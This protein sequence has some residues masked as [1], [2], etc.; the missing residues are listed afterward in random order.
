MAS[1]LSDIAAGREMLRRMT[2]D[3]VAVRQV[4]GRGGVV[5]EV[6]SFF[7]MLAGVVQAGHG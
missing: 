5:D 3:A 1:I 4:R 2:S 6:L 7:E